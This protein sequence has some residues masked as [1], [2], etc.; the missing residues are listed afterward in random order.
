MTGRREWL[1]QLR[2]ESGLTQ[3]ELSQ[4]IGYGVNIIGRWES[5]AKEPGARGLRL[6]AEYFR[7]PLVDLNDEE[8]RY[9]FGPN[10]ETIGGGI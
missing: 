6:L 3:K 1:C 10:W 8:L 7:V 5:G 9:L 2:Q 4:A